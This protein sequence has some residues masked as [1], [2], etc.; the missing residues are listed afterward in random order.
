MPSTTGNILLTV[1]EGALQHLLAGAR[2]NVG[3]KA[4]RYAFEVRI[5]ETL[6]P[7]PLQNSQLV[8]TSP[9]TSLRVGFSTRSSAMILGDGV[10]NACFDETGSFIHNKMRVPRTSGK[11]TPIFSAENS[12]VVVLVL[13]RCLPS[14]L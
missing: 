11:M 6:T 3:M 7:A 14:C 12:I 4:G 13:I 8:V 2:A 10:D 9:K 5:V 1:K